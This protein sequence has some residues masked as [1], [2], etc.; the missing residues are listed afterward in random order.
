MK[1]YQKKNRL[2]ETN[3]KCRWPIHWRSLGIGGCVL[4]GGGRCLCDLMHCEST[5]FK[6][7]NMM[8]TF[9]NLIDSEFLL[10]RLLPII[11][12]LCDTLT[13]LQV[14]HCPQG[15]RHLQPPLEV[16]APEPSRA[17]EP[18]L[19]RLLPHLAGRPSASASS[20]PPAIHSRLPASAL[21]LQHL[22]LLLSSSIPVC[23][24]P[25]PPFYT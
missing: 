8:I 2:E 21:L 23:C 19:A 14:V 15:E 25:S 7:V 1:S 17:L 9:R 24:P 11:K 13:H 4:F 16:Q 20:S 22:L 3:I 10:N 12:A 5:R 6:H 18:H